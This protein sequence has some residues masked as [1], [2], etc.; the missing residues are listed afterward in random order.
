[1]AR[2]LERSISRASEMQDM[3]RHDDAAS[4]IERR[5]TR[6]ISWSWTEALHFQLQAQG[7]PEKGGD[8]KS[9][10]RYQ[11]TWG[12]FGKD[13]SIKWHQVGAGKGGGTEASYLES[14][15]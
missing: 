10:S 7:L 3:Q 9:Y 4:T 5:P 1:M 8:D 11:D 13:Q 12:V 6:E 2:Q 15:Q 14:R